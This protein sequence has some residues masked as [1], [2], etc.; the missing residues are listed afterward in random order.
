MLLGIIL[1]FPTCTLTLQSIINV[2]VVNSAVESSF[3]IVF[4]FLAFWNHFTF[5]ALIKLIGFCGTNPAVYWIFII[6][7]NQ[8]VTHSKVKTNYMQFF[9]TAAVPLLFYH[10]NKKRENQ[11]LNSN[12]PGY[13]LLYWAM[14]VIFT[15]LATIYFFLILKINHCFNIIL[16]KATLGT[17]FEKFHSQFYP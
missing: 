6:S 12:C 9:C 2:H 17:R 4:F 1:K 8:M 15:K 11:S 7:A 14:N 5:P 13:Q 16:G 10:K 3:R